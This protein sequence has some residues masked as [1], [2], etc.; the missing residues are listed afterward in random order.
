MDR[1]SVLCFGGTYGLALACDLA[2]FAVKGAARWYATLA[3]TDPGLGHCRRL[4]WATW[5][6]RLAKLPVSTVFESLLVLSWV[7][8][9]VALYLIVRA[10]KPVAVGVFVLPVVLALVVRGR[11]LGPSG[12][13]GRVGLERG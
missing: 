2:R 1:L 6:S 13:L 7:L 8:A 10:P 5:R 12:G 9:A 4:T 3:L 11:R